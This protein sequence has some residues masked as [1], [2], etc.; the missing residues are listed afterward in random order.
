MISSMF[1]NA[2]SYANMKCFTKFRAFV[3]LTY[4]VM[5]LKAGIL[6]SL[7]LPAHYELT[8]HDGLLCTLAF[9]FLKCF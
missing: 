7:L 5:L 9:P 3:S 1:S 6:R 4:Q 2:V 8:L